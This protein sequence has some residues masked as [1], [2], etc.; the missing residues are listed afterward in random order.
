VT[1]QLDSVA[2]L[3]RGQGQLLPGSFRSVVFEADAR[4][5]FHD[6]ADLAGACRH[7]D[8]AAS[9]RWDGIVLAY[10]VDHEFSVVYAGKHYAERG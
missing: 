3:A 8:D 7:A 10:V 9:E 5:R 2:A 4:V 1:E 6:H